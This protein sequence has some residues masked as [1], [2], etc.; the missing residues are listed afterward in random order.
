MID[1]Q[2]Q[3]GCYACGDRYHNDKG[4]WMAYQS[5]HAVTDFNDKNYFNV[6]DT[7]TGKRRHRWFLF[8]L[9]LEYAIIL[10]QWCNIL[11]ILN[12]N[13]CLKEVKVW[14]DMK[15]HTFKWKTAPEWPCSSSEV[16]LVIYNKN[17]FKSIKFESYAFSIIEISW[18]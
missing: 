11:N 16:T 18:K 14:Q 1:F 17:H 8:A 13:W 12:K 6:Q 7:K 9:L 2:P 3:I 5:A 15:N 10:S 4:R